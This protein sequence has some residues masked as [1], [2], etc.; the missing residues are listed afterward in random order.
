MTP[1]DV[2]LM[3]LPSRHNILVQMS[4]EVLQLRA[5]PACHLRL[6]G[7]LCIHF[8]AVHFTPFS[9]GQPVCI[10]KLSSRLP[11]EC[12]DQNM[13][14]SPCTSQH[15]TAFKGTAVLSK[16]SCHQALLSKLSTHNS[17][18]CRP[19]MAGSTDKQAQI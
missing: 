9:T 18:A 12:T 16:H 15:N 10:E 11:S 1:S 13:N 17:V 5:C 6:K 2:T 7:L 4:D 8:V 14:A 3:A 19:P